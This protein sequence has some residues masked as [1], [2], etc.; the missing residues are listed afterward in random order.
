MDLA[1]HK[2][3]WIVLMLVMFGVVMSSGGLL[4]DLPRD[5]PE[6]MAAVEA[7]D[8]ENF[9]PDFGW[10]VLVTGGAWYRGV[11]EGME[12]PCTLIVQA[13]DGEMIAGA[14]VYG[15]LNFCLWGPIAEETI[16]AA[17]E[18]DADIIITV[19]Q[20][21]PAALRLEQYG[22]NTSYGGDNYGVQKGYKDED[23]NPVYEPIDPDGPSW[24]ESTLDLERIKAAV[25]A[26][27]IPCYIGDKYHK[28]GY[29]DTWFSSAGSYLCNYMA[30][31]VPHL[32]AREGMDDVKYLFIHHPTIPKYAA[33]RIQG[34]RD[35]DR[36]S[37][38]IDMMIEAIRIVIK[39]AV[40]AESGHRMWY[41]DDK[42]LH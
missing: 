19:G 30:Y 8:P 23:G 36:A 11:P 5:D 29:G 1:G 17:K 9:N 31:S 37:M 14:R 41:T 7:F 34:G 18:I 4:A 26:A 22:C 2:K 40:D 21:G 10:R 3:W 28:E 42:P 32:L 25:L 27:G 12:S 16:K 20:G 15:Q 24:Y 13:L 33:M 39:E 6:A 38:D 35:P